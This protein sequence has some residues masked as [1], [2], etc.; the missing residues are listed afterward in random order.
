MCA[1]N[2]PMLPPVANGHYCAK[3]VSMRLTRFSGFVTI[4][5]TLLNVFVAACTFLAACSGGTTTLGSSVTDASSDPSSDA[6]LAN[7]DDAAGVAVNDAGVT[8]N[9]A[10]V[11]VDPVDH[12]DAGDAQSAP[13]DAGASACG[14]TL[15][16]TCPDGGAPVYADVA[17]F[18]SSRCASCHTG[19]GSAPWPLAT[20][21]DVVNWEDL[22][23][24]DL[25]QCTMP[26]DDAGSPMP[27][28]E[29]MTILRWIACGMP[30]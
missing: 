7:V 20:Y 22:I 18:F 4:A 12:A 6:S 10:G 11:V 8:V 9:D 26:P 15:P 28:D 27:L 16:V 30:H 14:V 21:S 13:G 17:P 5:S 19:I 2:G 3:L 25:D 23:R 24:A 29:R 1:R